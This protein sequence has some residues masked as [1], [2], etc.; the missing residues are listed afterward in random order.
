MRSSGVGGMTRCPQIVFAHDRPAGWR[1]QVQIHS[2]ALG[3]IRVGY[4]QLPC[5]QWHQATT[6][7]R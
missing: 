5:L 2:Q 7:L 1:G 6:W 4:T 3:P